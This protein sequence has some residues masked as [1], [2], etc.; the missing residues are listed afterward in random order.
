MCLS[1]PDAYRCN[2]DAN[3][4]RRDK[5]ERPELCRGSV[6][7]VAPAAFLQKPAQVRSSAASHMH[8]HTAPPFITCVVCCGLVVTG[9]H[10]PVCVGC[11]YVF[12]QYRSGEHCSEEYSQL[13]RCNG[14]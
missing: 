9:S 12:D 6:E 7:F 11:V 5:M 13:T 4:F 2:L 1:V 10:I 8:T 3:G 14:S